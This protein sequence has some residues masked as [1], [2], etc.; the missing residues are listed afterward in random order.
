MALR[1]FDRKI[2]PSYDPLL[3]D[4]VMIIRDNEEIGTLSLKGLIMFISKNSE[5]VGSVGLGDSI[6]GE[7]KPKQE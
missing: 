6:D 3:T 1:K 2:G 7:L 4:K 5:I